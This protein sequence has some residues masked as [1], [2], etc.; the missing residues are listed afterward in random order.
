MQS[1]TLF[2]PCQPPWHTLFIQPPTRLLVIFVLHLH[3]LLRDVICACPARM[4]HGAVSVAF[5]FVIPFFALQCL[6][7]SP[8]LCERCIFRKDGGEERWSKDVVRTELRSEPSCSS[9]SSKSTKR[10]KTQHGKTARNNCTPM[11]I[12]TIILCALPLRLK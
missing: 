4:C 1:L 8:L 2:H 7:G 6:Q 12:P 5:Y 10:T 9:T 11:G 3:V